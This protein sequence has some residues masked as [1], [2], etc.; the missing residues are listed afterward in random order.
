[1]GG[2]GAQTWRLGEWIQT[3]PR[4]RRALPEV[5]LHA[6]GAAVR[7]A[8]GLV[9]SQSWTRGQCPGAAGPLPGPP[10]APFPP[11]PP[12]CPAPPGVSATHTRTPEGWSEMARQGQ[13]HALLAWVQF[14]C[15]S[16]PSRPFCCSKNDLEKSC[17]LLSP[18]YMVD[19][20]VAHVYTLS[21]LIFN[22][23]AITC[24]E[25]THWKR[26]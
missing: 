8:D 3:G 22:T 20:K 11:R 18:G 17:Y 10:H 4:P 5:T 12:A 16:R 19:F 24:E 21:Y 2:P 6:V 13:P 15:P 14:L 23:L 1:M 25:P 26:P 7:R 9:G